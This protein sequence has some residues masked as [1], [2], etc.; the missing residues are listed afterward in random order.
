[1]ALADDDAVSEL[2]LHNHTTKHSALWPSGIAV[3]MIS[4]LLSQHRL[5]RSVLQTFANRFLNS[6]KKAI[7]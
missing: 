4:I 6:V 1:M 7:S 3:S 5:R 2:W